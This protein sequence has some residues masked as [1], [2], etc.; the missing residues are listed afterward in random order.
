MRGCANYHRKGANASGHME[1][2]GPIPIGAGQCWIKTWVDG[3]QSVLEVIECTSHEVHY[4]VIHSEPGTLDRGTC[5][6]T[7]V[8]D[9]VEGNTYAGM[10]CQPAILIDPSKAHMLISLWH[11]A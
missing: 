9:W 5:T 1:K 3:I 2:V 6:L 7:Q 8:H 10:G 4:L 11:R